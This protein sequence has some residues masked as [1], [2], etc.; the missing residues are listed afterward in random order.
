MKKI[1]FP[2]F[3]VLVSLFSCEKLENSVPEPVPELPINVITRNDYFLELT[4]VDS[5][6]RIVKW[7]SQINGGVNY[8]N[9]QMNGICGNNK[10]L[11]S[12]SSSFANSGDTN[13]VESFSFWTTKCVSDTANAFFDSV[14]QEMSYPVQFSY[15]DS[16]N[17]FQ[18]T[19]LDS[20][21][22]L[23]MS[24]GSSWVND[25]AQLDHSLTITEVTKS[26]DALSALEIRGSFTG[27][28]Y[29]IDGD[30]Q[31]IREATFF[32]KARAY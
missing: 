31:L 19:Y 9:K 14:Y 2:A 7:E 23:W 3:V 24:D 16:I 4:L 27:W 11:V 25:S 28:L 32:S 1:V 12:Y 29:N 21:T 17:S 10:T 5:A 6:T 30:S 8:T 15:G 18:F 20:D 26:Y 22:M 13:N